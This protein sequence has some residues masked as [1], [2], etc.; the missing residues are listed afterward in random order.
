MGYRGEGKEREERVYGFIVFAN[1]IPIDKETFID[2]VANEPSLFCA[3]D[4]GLKKETRSLMFLVDGDKSRTDEAEFDIY[5]QI[6]RKDVANPRWDLLDYM[7]DRAGRSA[8][9]S[10]ARVYGPANGP[11]GDRGH[12]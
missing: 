6:L 5:E 1:A 3:E 7:Y 2:A 8:T 9:R 12:A 10:M 4:A 11:A